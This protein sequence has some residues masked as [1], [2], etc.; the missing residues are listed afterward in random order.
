LASGS[1][2]LVLKR[3]LPFCSQY[4]II[5]PD[6]SQWPEIRAFSKLWA[7]PADPEKKV[8]GVR[9]Q[10]SGCGGEFIDNKGLD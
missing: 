10:V 5:L 4:F 1:V 3:H 9:F 2:G 8:S 7:I 6:S